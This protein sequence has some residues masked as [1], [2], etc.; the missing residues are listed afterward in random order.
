MKKMEDWI[1][2]F[3]RI[4]EWEWYDDPITKSVWL[5]ILLTANY[6]DKH[7][8]GIEIKRGQLLTSTSGLSESFRGKDKNGNRKKKSSISVKQVRT[9]L[10]HLKWTK[11]VAIQTT[12]NYTLITVNKYNDYQQVANETANEGQTRGKRGATTKEYKNIRNKEEKRYTEKNLS[13]KEISEKLEELFFTT[14]GKRQKLP[15]A[16][17]PNLEYWLET[18]EAN[19]IAKAIVNIKHDE[20]WK[21][22]MTLTVLLRKR[23]QQGEPVD[24]ISQLL[25]VKKN[26]DE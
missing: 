25:S 12:P 2:L 11:E 19:D 18:H 5:E 17:F 13:L 14:T 26:Y 9:A 16:S 4:R 21:D 24:Y 1:K 15:L 20:F 22:K 8:H 23:N 7:W 6:E 3:R 10:E